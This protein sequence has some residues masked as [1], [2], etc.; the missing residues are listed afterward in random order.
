MNTSP[1][2]RP[3]RVAIV[4]LGCA[5]NTVDS[6]QALGR[7]LG[8]GFA[9]AA[10]PEEADLVLVNTCG[11]I[12]SAKQESI[13][14]LLEI[15]ALK[16]DRPDLRVVAMGCLVERYGADLAQSIPELDGL[17]PFA[18]YAGLSEHCE[19]ILAG[20]R[21]AVTA[22]GRGIPLDA[23]A[24]LILTGS[25]YAYLRIADGCDNRCAYCAVPFIRGGF[26]SRPEDEILAEAR[27]LVGQG[28]AEL[29]LVAQDTTRYGFD[30]WGARRL[31]P[32]LRR[33]LDEVEGDPW[34]RV[35]Y[36]HPAHLDTEVIDLLA[37]EARLLGYLDLPIQHINDAILE[38]MGR[39]TTR[40]QIERH[41]AALRH[42]RPDFVLR[43]ACI[44]GLPGETEAAFEELLAFV[45]EGHFQHLGAFAYS[46]EEGTPAAEMP[47]AVDPEVA[48]ERAGRLMEAQQQV[49]FRW[50]EERLGANDEVLVQEVYEDG[51]AIGRTRAEAPEVDGVVHLDGGFFRPCERRNAC[52][53]ERRDYDL[54]AM[55]D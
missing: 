54:L 25:A 3:Q 2:E 40:T 28:V 49:T 24:R 43:T 33:L 32:L 8:S 37:G 29:C 52:L 6:E 20:E 39:R 47:D 14:H 4:D 42:R 38:R 18:G 22:E 15:A 5:K 30:R 23:G 7:L 1:L 12:E 41:I 51:T 36:A 31:A 13:E 45:R 50:L 21:V 53:V 34:I 55:P 9:F 44:T 16:E 48:E 35:L 46:P 19:R 17:I 27:D 10:D 11:F 26:R